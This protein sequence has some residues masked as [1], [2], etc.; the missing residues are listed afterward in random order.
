MINISPAHIF[1][2]S[3]LSSAL[4]EVVNQWRQTVYKPIET[5]K[6]VLNATIGLR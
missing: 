5:C 3:I 6:S 4:K 1:D 2:A